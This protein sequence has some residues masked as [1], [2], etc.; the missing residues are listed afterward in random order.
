MNWAG[1]M[2]FV[3]GQFAV[4]GHGMQN[5]HMN[6]NYAYN[7]ANAA[8]QQARLAMQNCKD[9]AKKFLFLMGLKSV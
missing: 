8:D 3:P 9:L 5:V 4:N 2:G 1:G 6:V 7:A